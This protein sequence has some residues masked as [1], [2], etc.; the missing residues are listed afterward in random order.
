MQERE[1]ERECQLNGLEV[2]YMIVLLLKNGRH[3]N[4]MK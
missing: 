2:G 1:R 3:K 4:C